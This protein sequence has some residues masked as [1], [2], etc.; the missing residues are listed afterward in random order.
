MIRRFFEQPGTDGTAFHDR[1]LA[2]GL[3]VA[4]VTVVL[5]WALNIHGALTWGW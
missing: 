2:A 4:R 1:N 3:F 5:L